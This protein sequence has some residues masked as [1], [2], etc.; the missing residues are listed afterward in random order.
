MTH[1]FGAALNDVT[2]LYGG[3]QYY[4]EDPDKVHKYKLGAR[5]WDVEFWDCVAFKWM[6]TQLVF[7]TA[8]GWMV[9]EAIDQSSNPLRPWSRF[10]AFLL[11]L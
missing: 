5:D 10:F 3:C 7:F 6:M 4:H 8:M 11:Y 1:C 2:I 9:S